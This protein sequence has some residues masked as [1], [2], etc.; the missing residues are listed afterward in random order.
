M[1]GTG[2]VVLLA[3]LRT[4][5]AEL[6]P[7][8]SREKL[9]AKQKVARDKIIEFNPEETRTKLSVKQKLTRDKMI[10]LNPEET[11]SVGEEFPKKDCSEE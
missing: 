5:V 7:E 3:R 9:A 4:I 11:R 6:N 1:E 10:K 8:E 2:K